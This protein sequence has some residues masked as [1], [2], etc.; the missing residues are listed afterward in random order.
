MFTGFELFKNSSNITSHFHLAG[1]VAE[2]AI[3]RGCGVSDN[4]GNVWNWLSEP[5]K[6][7]RRVSS[8]GAGVIKT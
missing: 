4:L 6:G 5:L 1:G 3:A 7:G 2:A 8:E